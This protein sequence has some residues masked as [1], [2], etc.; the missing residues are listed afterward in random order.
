MTR[1]EVIKELKFWFWSCSVVAILCLGTSLATVIYLSSVN[2]LNSID[3]AILVFSQLLIGILLS[4]PVNYSSNILS[5]KF[6]EEQ[7]G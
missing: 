4:V 3:S 7:Y 6:K 5:K 1:E 2:S